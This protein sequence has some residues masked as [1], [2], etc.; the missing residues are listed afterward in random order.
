VQNVWAP[1]AIQGS[2][3]VNDSNLCSVEWRGVL[4]WCTGA[5]GDAVVVA[6]AVVHAT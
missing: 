1:W 6:A 2:S 4:W 5:T 3:Q